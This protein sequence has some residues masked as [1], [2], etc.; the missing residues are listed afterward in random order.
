MGK[1]IRIAI[2]YNQPVTGSVEGRKYVAENG[3]LQSELSGRRNGKQAKT[4]GRY[5]T[6]DISEMGVLEEMEDIK[7]ALNALGYR[8]TTFNVDSDIFHLIDVLRGEKPDLIF[9]LVECVE[10]DS[11]QEMNVAGLYEL[12]KIP[13]TGAGSLTLGIALDKPRVKEILAAH[14]IRTPR[15]QVFRMNDKIELD[16][17]LSFPVIVKPS[18]EDASVGISDDSVVYSPADLRK[19]VRYIHSEFKQPALVEQ[20]VEGRE[21]NVAIM[22]NKKPVV[23]PISEIDFSGLTADMH[24]IVSYDAKWMQ[25]TVAYVGT[26]GVCPA[27]LS[28]EDETAMKDIALRCYRII[29]C[30]DY[31]RVDIRLAKN[32]TPYVLE[33]NPNP[34]ISDDAGFA[35]SAKAHGLAFNQVVG[36]IVEY[37]L[38]R[39][40]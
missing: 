27:R 32:G 23:F 22:G 9:N 5:E 6:V 17:K 28:P 24:R 7:C 40:H 20:Y 36:K 26:Q 39:C 4:N 31:A 16:P 3:K 18:R 33:V 8:A 14:G 34:D 15:Y 21:I 2:L 1:K 29:G 12:L 13:Y 30:R 37:A 19:R 11:D 38:E 35:R 25:G 10:N